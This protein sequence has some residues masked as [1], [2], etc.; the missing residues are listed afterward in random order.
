MIRNLAFFILFVAST[1]ASSTGNLRH[2]LEENNIAAPA[3]KGPKGKEPKSK[4]KIPKE[5]SEAEVN[6]ALAAWG[7]GL[8]AISTAYRNGGDYVGIARTVIRDNYNF[9]NGVTLFKP[10]LASDVPFRTSFDAALSYFVGGIAGSPPFIAE[11]TGF[12]KPWKQVNFEL[13]GVILGEKDAKVMGWKRLKKTDDTPV[14]AQFSMSFIRDETTGGLKINL[15][16]S[17][18]PY[19]P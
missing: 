16:H 13:A 11:D 4:P 10:T 15:H 6:A 14:S 12:A 5:V 18:L 2:A 3:S 9:D 17:S 1:S 19:M 8:V 7:D